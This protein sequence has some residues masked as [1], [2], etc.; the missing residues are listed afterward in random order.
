MTADILSFDK[1][2]ISNNGGAAERYGALCKMATQYFHDEGVNIYN[3]NVGSWVGKGEAEL[4][5]DR[6]Q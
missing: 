6:I 2:D 5:T 3:W 4:S 1:A